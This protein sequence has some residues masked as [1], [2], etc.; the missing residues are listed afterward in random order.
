MYKSF[1]LGGGGEKRGGNTRKAG[2]EP[3]TSATAE[4]APLYSRAL[5]T[6]IPLDFKI[7]TFPPPVHKGK[8][9]VCRSLP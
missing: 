7:L 8:L 9:T 2:Q 5:S 4:E 1:F 6:Q 3:T